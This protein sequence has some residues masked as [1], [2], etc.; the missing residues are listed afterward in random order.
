MLAFDSLISATGKAPTKNT[1]NDY[2]PQINEPVTEYNIVAVLI[3]CS[4]EATAEVRQEYEINTF[5]LDVCMKTL[6]IIGSSPTV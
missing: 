3:R 1:I 6:P 5:E 4:V 2:Y